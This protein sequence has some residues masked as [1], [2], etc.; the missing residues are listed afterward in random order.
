HL[1]LDPAQTDRPDIYRDGVV[2]DAFDITARC[3]RQFAAP[4]SDTYEDSVRTARR[5][6]GLVALRR[7]SASGGT[8]AAAVRDAL[9]DRSDWP[10]GLAR[11]CEQL[12]RG[13]RVALAAAATTWVVGAL[14]IVGSGPG[15]QWSPPFPKPAWNLPGWLV[16]VSAAVDATAG[17]TETGDRLL[18]LADRAP[19]AD[20][21]LRSG[22]VALVWGVGK[23]EMPVRVALGAPATGTM[24][25]TTVDSAMLDLAVDRF[26]E[27]LSYRAD[28][29]SAPPL[30]WRGCA[31]CD[32]LDECEAGIVHVASLRLPGAASSGE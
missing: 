3:P 14:R 32:L 18:V 30:P 28:P 16:R 20:D 13:G 23:G 6:V 31:H 17:N 11:W 26:E 22:F 10:V 19:S 21:R 5:R 24:Q 25:R 2:L 15:T 8:P 12:D 9:A 7:L 1:R 29:A 4:S 27:L